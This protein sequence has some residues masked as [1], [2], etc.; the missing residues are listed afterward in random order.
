MKIII[1]E[2]HKEAHM[3]RVRQVVTEGMKRGDDKKEIARE[4]A[5]MVEYLRRARACIANR[6]YAKCIYC[7]LQIK[8]SVYDERITD[9]RETFQRYKLLKILFE[10]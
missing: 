2:D 10:L 4:V 5:L 8:Y 3:A 7:Q 9:P 1:F 6:F